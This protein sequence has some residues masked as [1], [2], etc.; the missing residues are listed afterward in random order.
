MGPSSE[1][2]RSADAAA[3]PF[4]TPL[5]RLAP[6]LSELGHAHLQQHVA[7]VADVGPDLLALA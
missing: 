7:R 1:A 4:N 6:F 5:R 3:C 2:G